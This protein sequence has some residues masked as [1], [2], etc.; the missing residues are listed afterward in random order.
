MKFKDKDKLNLTKELEDVLDYITG[1]YM[2]DSK[3]NISILIHKTEGDL[4][5][6]SHSNKD[7][8][9]KN[10]LI[11]GILTKVV[12]NLIYEAGFTDSDSFGTVCAMLEAFNSPVEKFTDLK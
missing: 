1:D 3:D 5:C 6:F 10:L 12:S 9:G 7:I 2:K 4:C 8:K 11:A